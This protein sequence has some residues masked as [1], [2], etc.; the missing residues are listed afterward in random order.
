MLC[1]CPKKIYNLLFNISIY[2]TKCI[3]IWNCLNSSNSNHRL[4]KQK[5]IKIRSPGAIN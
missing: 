4:Q 1:I 3:A 5:G 2:K